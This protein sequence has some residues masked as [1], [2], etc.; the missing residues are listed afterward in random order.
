SQFQALCTAL[1]S[2]IG[3]G[4][5]A[6]VAAAIAVGGP[7]AVMWMWVSAVFGMMTA[8][9]ENVLGI[10]YR[11]RDKSGKLLGGPMYYIRDGVGKKKGFKFLSTL[12]AP[13]FCIFCILASFG[14]GNM[15]QV[16]SISTA[17]RANFGISPVFCGISIA[18]VSAFIIVGGAKRV[19]RTTEKLVPAMALFYIL[20]TLYVMISNHHSI[21]Y[22]FSSILKSA[23]N[24]KAGIG[25]ATGIMLKKTVTLG[26]KRGIFSNEAGL[27]SSVI[28]HSIADVDEP[29]VQGMWGIF[30][31]FFDTIVICSLTAFALLS[32]SASAMPLD[33]ALSGITKE[34]RYVSL[35]DNG[36]QNADVLMDYVANSIYVP[37]S[38]AE[39]GTIYSV[40]PQNG[41]PFEIAVKKDTS[42]G[43]SLTYTN[44]MSVRGVSVDDD[45]II[46]DNPKSPINAVCFKKVEGIEL[47]TYAFSQHF[48]SFAGKIIAIAILLFA[49]STIVGWS[50][51]GTVAWEYLF[52]TKSVVIYKI[53][54]ILFVFLGAI[55]S[56]DLVWSLSDTFNGL[57]SIPNLVALVVLSG[58]VFAVTKKYLSKNK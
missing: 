44:L 27:G 1:S 30:T 34:T 35:Y 14:M 19:G 46:D 50:Y 18:V 52:G 49:F 23:F 51:Y 24:L 28:V 17:L 22:V 56:L 32:S 53:I 4:N 15:A 26:F 57:M 58:E 3:T 48:G 42:S 38:P 41:A 55:L 37:A 13:L 40:T 7:G 54:Y 39:T 45:G 8:Y 29:A 2:T 21:P 47:V 16:N 6:G 11:Q 9:A 5:I 43:D 20:A 36:S 12:L 33:E 10:S 31:V 25:G